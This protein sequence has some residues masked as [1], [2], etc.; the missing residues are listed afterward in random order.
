MHVRAC[1]LGSVFRD[2][3]EKSSLSGERK[4][5]IL[6]RCC[7]FMIACVK[8]TLKRLP[9]NMKLLGD[10]NLLHCYNIR[11]FS[12]DVIFK[13]FAKFI[14]P[15]STSA[16]ESEY[17]FLH[18]RLDEL[19]HENVTVFWKN[20]LDAKNSAGARMF[21]LLSQIAISLLTLPVSNAAIE[22]VLSQVTLTKTGLRD[23]MS[24]ETLENILH[25]K[26]GLTRGGKCC[27]DFTP[28]DI[29]LDRFNTTAMYTGG[30]VC[31]PN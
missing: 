31:T 16:M 1:Q 9:S 5:T 12:F 19:C 15:L 14:P 30:A 3:L 25:V 2:A 27:K 23:R 7:A 22:R 10:L 13:D 4:T 8:S 18:C 26:F 24:I 17:C 6:E 28:S 11:K 20:V 29:F 21:P